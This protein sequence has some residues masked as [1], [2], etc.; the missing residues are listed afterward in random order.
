M[1]LPNPPL[2]QS[3]NLP[4]IQMKGISPP[5]MDSVLG[6]CP[7]FLNNKSELCESNEFRVFNSESE[8]S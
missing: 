3:Y 4:K 8:I 2:N 5:T 1:G 7:N 6:Y